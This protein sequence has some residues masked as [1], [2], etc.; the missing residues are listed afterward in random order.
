MKIK[1][2][3]GF[4]AHSFVSGR[5]LMLGG[6]EIPYHKGLQGHSDADVLVHAI[7]DSLAGVGLGKDIGQLFPD[8]DSRYKSIDSKILLKKTVEMVNDNGYVISNIDAEVILQEPKLRSYIPLMCETLAG[9]A[10]ID[11]TDIAIKATTSEKMGFTGRKE[12]VAAIAVCLLIK[13]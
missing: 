5:P 6:I 7:V 1:T 13:N 3:I 2:G 8:N 4:D 10:G 9:V 12:G 11:I